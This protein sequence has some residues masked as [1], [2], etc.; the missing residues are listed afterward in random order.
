MWFNDQII[1]VLLA[2]IVDFTNNFI[3]TI[4]FFLKHVVWEVHGIR[5]VISYSD[6]FV[7]MKGA[8]RIQ[9]VC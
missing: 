2:G 6:I 1:K 8:V 9:Y 7:S 5:I 4:Q 3:T